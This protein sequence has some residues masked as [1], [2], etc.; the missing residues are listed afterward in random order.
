MF[1]GWLGSKAL[2]EMIRDALLPVPIIS[3]TTP[4]VR[5]PGWVCVNKS[6]AQRPRE[7]ETNQGLLLGAEL[8][9]TYLKNVTKGSGQ[10]AGRIK[11]GAY[12]VVCEH[13]EPLRNA[14]MGT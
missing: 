10:G 6:Q 2:P 7:K 9:R 4:A 13:F 14:A 11:S 1:T 8:S 12:A 5:L 3:T